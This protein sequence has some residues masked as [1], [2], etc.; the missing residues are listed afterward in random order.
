[1]SEEKDWYDC[2]PEDREAVLAFL[3]NKQLF[4]L[5]EGYLQKEEMSVEEQLLTRRFLMGNLL[6][7]N[8][9]RQ[10]AV[11]NIKM[12]E[13]EL[14]MVHK[15]SSKEGMVYKV[16]TIKQLVFFCQCNSEAIPFSDPKVHHVAQTKASQRL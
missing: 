11:I 9:Q 16:W 1:M 10:G 2:S 12:W 15:T 4:S 13:I 3:F 6:Y 5:V 8:A 7:R 14:G